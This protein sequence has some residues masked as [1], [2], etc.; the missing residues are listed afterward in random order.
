MTIVTNDERY[1]YYSDDA[2]MASNDSKNNVPGLNDRASEYSSLDNES[3][4]LAD[5]DNESE[6]HS[7]KNNNT[8]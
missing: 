6:Y 1:S 3:M 5:E 2:S 7:T 4:T 8:V